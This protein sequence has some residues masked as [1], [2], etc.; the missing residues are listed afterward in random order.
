MQFPTVSGFLV[1]GE[2]DRH[3]R[4][5]VWPKFGYRGADWHC[6]PLVNSPW[7]WDN[8]SRKGVY[9]HRLFGLEVD[10]RPDGLARLEKVKG[11]VDLFMMHVM[12]DIRINIEI[13]AQ[14]FIHHSRQLAAAQNTTKRRAPPDATCHK[15]ER[16]GCDLLACARHTDHGAFPP[17]FVTGFQR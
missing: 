17:T 14:P 5:V 10:H 7:R 4:Y 13:T 3:F 9:R 11:R 16:S 1:V 8:R 12:G 15:L 2:Q 6:G